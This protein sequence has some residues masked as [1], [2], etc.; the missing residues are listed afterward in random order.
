MKSWNY[1]P[2]LYIGIY[3]ARACRRDLLAALAAP[4][5][6]NMTGGIIQ[7]TDQGLAS[8]TP[9][10]A[11]AYFQE[12]KVALKKVDNDNK[13]E[14]SCIYLIHKSVDCYQTRSFQNISMWFAV[15]V[16][17]SAKHSGK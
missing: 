7:L 12:S 5:I 3:L 17:K 16:M 4:L 15:T 13:L 8:L 6:S 11:A 9:Y 14:F 10:G 2:G 1:L